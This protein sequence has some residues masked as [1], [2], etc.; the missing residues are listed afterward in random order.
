MSYPI[1]GRGP[2]PIPPS[3][4]ASQYQAQSY[5][6]DYQTPAGPVLPPA[7]PV[8]HVTA[9]LV[10][11]NTLTGRIIRCCKCTALI[12]T[13]G[14]FMSAFGFFGVLAGKGMRDNGVC[15]NIRGYTTKY[16][17]EFAGACD[18]II[19]N[20]CPEVKNSPSVVT[21]GSSGSSVPTVTP[22]AA[23]EIAFNA[24][25]VQLPVLFSG[26]K[27]STTRSETYVPQSYSN[28]EPSLYKQ[29]ALTNEHFTLTDK[30]A[31]YVRDRFPPV[32]TCG[33]ERKDKGSEAFKIMVYN[34]T[35]TISTSKFDGTR[36]GSGTTSHK[37]D[38]SCPKKQNLNMASSRNGGMEHYTVCNPS[39]KTFAEYKINLNQFINNTITTANA[40]GITTAQMKIEFDK[41]V[42]AFEA[43][44]LNATG[45]AAFVKINAND[46]WINGTG[47]TD[48]LY[49]EYDF[50]AP[51]STDSSGPYQDSRGPAWAGGLFLGAV[52]G[53]AMTLL[54]Q[55]VAA[56]VKRCCPDIDP[57][58]I[59]AARA[60]RNA[61]ANSHENVQMLPIYAS[62]PD[63]DQYPSSALQ[64]DGAGPAYSG[65]GGE[66]APMRK[67]KGTL[68]FV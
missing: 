40:T 6:Q 29:E 52:G 25:K 58:G 4:D 67:S 39:S 15:N 19:G 32:N 24:A 61:A 68:H 43:P 21:C 3:Y 22:E 2:T 12:L 7:D 66:E 42:T 35:C 65:A 48:S 55:K 5:A 1:S 45:L 33:A 28:G 36:F 64:F 38:F 8:P 13:G 60:R 53:V 20:P 44:S 27:F 47:H 16:A 62:A 34:S 46:M 18:A 14:F 30:Y 56:K 37:K 31:A 57:C 11:C 17:S 26:A 10:A 41:L 23:F 59:G 9:C 50:S 49:P 63:P 54:G 51:N